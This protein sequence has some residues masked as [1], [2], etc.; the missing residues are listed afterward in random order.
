VLVM[1]SLILGCWALFSSEFVLVGFIRDIQDLS[2]RFFDDWD[3]CYTRRHRHMR[4]NEYMKSSF[5][6]TAASSF[7]SQCFSPFV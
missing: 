6:D 2:L 7:R 5:N 3:L 1:G 4:E